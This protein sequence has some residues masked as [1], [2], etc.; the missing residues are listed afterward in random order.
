[1][2]SSGHT[3]FPPFK[4]QL[5]MKTPPHIPSDEAATPIKE[6]TIPEVAFQT[7]HSLVIFNAERQ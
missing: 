5:C 3:W 7:M 6:Q 4:Q 2:E 1:M